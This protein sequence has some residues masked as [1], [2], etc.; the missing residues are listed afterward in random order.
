MKQR[1]KFKSPDEIVMKKDAMRIVTIISVVILLGI[2]AILY[3]LYIFNSNDGKS[4][5]SIKSEE[6]RNV[7]EY[8]DSV[9]KEKMKDVRPEKYDEDEIRI[10][11]T[12]E[13]LYNYATRKKDDIVSIKYTVGYDISLDEATAKIVEALKKISINAVMSEEKT[14]II[15]D[16]GYHLGYNS[17][18]KSLVN[19]RYVVEI[20]RDNP[21]SIVMKY[22]YHKADGHKSGHLEDS[23]DFFSKVL[24]FEVRNSF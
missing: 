19:F 22:Y 11:M 20:S 15:F 5:I 10:V 21:R 3:F 17:K 14:K 18:A 12:D 8:L 4:D 2:T 9:Y 24:A 1:D 6:Q 23:Y 16:S 13:Q 7:N